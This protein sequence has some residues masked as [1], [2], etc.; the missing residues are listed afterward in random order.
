M[1]Q[2]SQCSFWQEHDTKFHITCFRV[3]FSWSNPVFKSINITMV[4]FSSPLDQKYNTKRDLVGSRVE[5]KLLLMLDKKSRICLALQSHM[6]FLILFFFLFTGMSQT[7]VCVG[8]WFSPVY[9]SHGI[10][11]VL[12]VLVKE[13]SWFQISIQ[14][15]MI[16]E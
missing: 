10:Q 13:T 1:H 12:L 5:R 11:N 2:E 3:G 9:K 7:N 15:N 6:N 4:E 14:E 16:I 8:P